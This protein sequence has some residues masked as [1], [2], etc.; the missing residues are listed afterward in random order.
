MSV[1][2][3]FVYHLWPITTSNVAENR[4]SAGMGGVFALPVLCACHAHALR[5]TFI[6]IFPDS[7]P[8]VTITQ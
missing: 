3:R 4:T 2:W 1:I 7:A 6:M 8:K 5:A